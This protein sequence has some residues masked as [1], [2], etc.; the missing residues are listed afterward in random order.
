MRRAVMVEHQ[1][2]VPGRVDVRTPNVAEHVHRS[3]SW[4]PSELCRASPQKALPQGRFN[5]W[6]GAGPG[7][8]TGIDLLVK[9]RGEEHAL[10][11]AS[12]VT[13]GVHWEKYHFVLIIF[14][15][16][17]PIILSSW[18]KFLSKVQ[19]TCCLQASSSNNI[20]ALTD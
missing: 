9:C 5:P 18:P 20:K 7:R 13:E 3:S 8:L 6:V 15:L 1:V 16:F 14:F 11:F 19:P 12:L 2:H 10:H 4:V 17:L